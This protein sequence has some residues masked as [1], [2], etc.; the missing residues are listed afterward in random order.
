M[1]FRSDESSMVRA[2]SLNQLVNGLSETRSQADVL[3]NLVGRLQGEMS[4]DVT[5][6]LVEVAT[7]L[8]GSTAGM[9]DDSLG[10]AVV[11][12]T[13]VTNT[14][15]Q[16]VRLL[17][18]KLGKE[19]AFDVVGDEGIS[20]DRQILER[21]SEPIRQVIV[22]A[23]THG[24]ETAETRHGS[25][26]PEEGQIEMRVE[27][28]EGT[29]QLEI[30]DDGAGID[31]E[32]VRRIGADRGLVEPAD[33]AEE[34]LQALLFGDGFSTGDGNASESGRGLFL[35]DET[36][37]ALFGRVR[38]ASESGVGTT[39]TIA[40]PSARA[41]EKLLLVDAGGGLWALPAVAVEAMRPVADVTVVDAGETRELDWNGVNIPLRSLGAVAGV[42]PSRRD[43]NVLVVS[44][45]SGRAA[46]TCGRVRGNYELWVRHLGNSHAAPRHIFGMSI[47]SNGEEV[48]VL[49]AGRMVERAVTLP[50][51]N[52]H[53]EVRVLVVD[54]SRG[55]RAVI[56]GALASAGLMPSVAGSVAEALEILDE[57]EVDA[58]VVDFSMPNA[59]GIALVNEVRAR[60]NQMPIIMLSAVA[61]EEDQTRAKLAGVDAFFD[62]GSFQEGV[63]ADTLWQMLDR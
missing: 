30:S 48:L 1:L 43:E 38:I 21:L 56:S 5:S 45:R 55:A 57:H 39:V 63:I 61:G 33:V 24:I 12:V 60:K 32:A 36:V 27:L 8:Q 23:V 28:R 17:A 16:L 47:L 37:E 6:H 9:L 19:V 29:L 18:D 53:Q 49:D 15:P 14:L 50:D 20:V 51:D 58:L 44:H 25:R 31:W 10:L 11:P 22:N 59:D 54:D 2:G 7:S 34:E 46:F 62:K 4:S 26:K 35:V 40:V 41:L 42:S 13:S 52:S 3:V